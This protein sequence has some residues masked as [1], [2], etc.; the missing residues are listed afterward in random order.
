[1][2][3]L[4]GLITLDELLLGNNKI[5]DM[6]GLTNLKKLEHYDNYLDSGGYPVFLLLR[7]R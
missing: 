3:P 1:M 2:N 6:A 4:T 7:H 5:S